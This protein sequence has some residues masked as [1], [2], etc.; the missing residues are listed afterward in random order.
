MEM[1]EK[2]EGVSAAAAA[3]ASAV[4]GGEEVWRGARKAQ[5]HFCI[6]SDV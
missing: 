6:L 4:W 5:T 2:G 3:A 1:G